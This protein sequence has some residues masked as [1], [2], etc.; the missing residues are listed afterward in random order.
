MTGHGFVLPNPQCPSR[1]CRDC[2][3]HD[4]RP[5]K[6]SWLVLSSTLCKRFAWFAWATWPFYLNVSLC[7]SVSHLCAKRAME[8]STF[9]LLL[10]GIIIIHSAHTCRGEEISC[11]VP[12]WAWE[13]FYCNIEA[14]LWR[15]VINTGSYRHWQLLEQLLKSKMHSFRSL[16]HFWRLFQT[17]DCCSKGWPDYG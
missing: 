12:L 15:L 10:Y 16:Q 3:C 17:S 7:L 5:F 13:P 8:L 9:C 1:S 14:A 6:A 2:Q 11:S 4:G